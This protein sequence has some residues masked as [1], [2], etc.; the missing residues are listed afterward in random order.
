[1]PKSFR[2]GGGL[3][4]LTPGDLRG[5]QDEK[6]YAYASYEWMKIQAR[7]F[8]F[9]GFISLFKIVSPQYTKIREK[10]KPKIRTFALHSSETGHHANASHFISSNCSSIALVWV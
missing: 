3:R 8:P 7:R 5:T 2:V 9:E 6:S 4:R 1:L 10:M